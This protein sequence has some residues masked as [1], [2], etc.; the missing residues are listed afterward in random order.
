MAA[1]HLCGREMTTGASCTL[2]VLH[3]HGLPFPMARYG[4]E[5]SRPAA[6]GRCGDCG[7]APGAFHHPG[8]DLQDCPACGGQLL[9]CGCSFDEDGF[10]QDDDE[11][12][13]DDEFDLDGREGNGW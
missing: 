2:E 8:C 6:V 7:V 11:D 13:Q 5:P 1:C 10:E 12:E 9:S 3:R 4:N